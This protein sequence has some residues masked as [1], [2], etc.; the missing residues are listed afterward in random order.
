MTQYNSIY[1]ESIKMLNLAKEKMPNFNSCV[2]T[3]KWLKHYANRIL[4]INIDESSE[5][6]IVYKRKYKNKVIEFN[7]KQYYKAVKKQMNKLNWKLR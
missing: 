4:D 2:T 7:E 1:K 6:D 5:S 3:R